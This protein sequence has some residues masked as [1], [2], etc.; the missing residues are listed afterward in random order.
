MNFRVNVSAHVLPFKS[1]VVS[2][3]LD[4]PALNPLITVDEVFAM[5]K[6]TGLPD[7]F[8]HVYLAALQ[9]H[10]D[11]GS[12][13]NGNVYMVSFMLI[14]A[15]ELALN[16]RRTDNMMIIFLIRNLVYR[17]LESRYID[18]TEE[19]RPILNNRLLNYTAFRRSRLS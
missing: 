6:I 2:D 16:D 19:I 12:D 5:E 8:P 10:D 14:T 18:R 7:T 15:C 3:I 17:L 1:S 11:N 9:V 4:I 13:I